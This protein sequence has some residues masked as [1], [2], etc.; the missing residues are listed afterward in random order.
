MTFA[1]WMKQVNAECINL[2]GCS[3]YDLP[4]FTFRDYYDAGA[5]PIEAA[6]DAI[7]EAG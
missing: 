3:I 4:D 1:Q 5:S 7:D 6:T 2:T